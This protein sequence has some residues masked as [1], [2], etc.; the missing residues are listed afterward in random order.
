MSQ[1]ALGISRALSKKSTVAAMFLL[2]YVLRQVAK[3]SKT[4]QNEKLDLTSSLVEAILHTIDDA[5]NPT[6]NWVLALRDIR[7]R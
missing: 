5:L 2:E 4:L 3:L 7:R 6:A 1:S